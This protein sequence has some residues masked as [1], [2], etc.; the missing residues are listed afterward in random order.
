MK[1]FVVGPQRTASSWLD[2]ALRSH[3]EIALPAHVKETF[4]FDSEYSRGLGWYSSFFRY[5]G[6]DR[7]C[8][9]V[10]PTY[11][12]SSDARQRIQAA[13]GKPKIIILVRNPVARSFS[14]FRHAYTKGRVGKEF[15]AAIRRRPAIIDAGRYSV[16]A[17]EWEADVGSE[18]VLYLVQEDI[19]ADPQAE[20]D[21]VCRFLDVERTLL[22]DTLKARYGQ[23]TVPRFQWLAGLAA[24]CVKE[25]RRAGL[26]RVVELGKALG[27]KRVY[28]GGLQDSFSMNQPIFEYLLREHEPDIRFLE[29]KLG[30]TFAHWRDPAQYDLSGLAKVKPKVRNS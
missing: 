4:F 23:G 2:R 12:N 30:R 17:P 20:F 6:V 5:A 21:A 8:G 29:N 27:L 11:F 13:Y 22:P 26:H 24:R 28:A 18:Q 16:H 9:E 15:G 25:L 10:G 19:E 7:I 14:A 1:F 3:A